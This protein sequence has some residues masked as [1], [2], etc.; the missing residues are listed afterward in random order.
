MDWST[1]N[2]AKANA[3][4][5]RRRTS[6]SHCACAAATPSPMH[7]A[8]MA[9]PVSG[10]RAHGHHD[11]ARSG[12]TNSATPMPNRTTAWT[13]IVARTGIDSGRTRGASVPGRR[14]WTTH[15]TTMMIGTTT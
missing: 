12:A 8:P 14:V 9:R 10:V 5:C 15:S 3:A 6:F 4:G 1:P 2:V 13:E 7:H 11:A